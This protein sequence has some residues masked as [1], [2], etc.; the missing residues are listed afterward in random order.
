V[1]DKWIQEAVPKSHRGVF[2]AKAEKAGKGVQEYARS[3]IAKNKRGGGVGSKLLHEALF[4]R[5]AGRKGGFS[6]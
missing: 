5:T 4:A 1:A 2:T 6:A 3:V